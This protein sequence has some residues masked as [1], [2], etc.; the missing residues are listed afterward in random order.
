MPGKIVSTFDKVAADLSSLIEK[1][2]KIGQ[3]N[4]YKLQSD[5]NYYYKAI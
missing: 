3:R 4:F 5:K 1:D 2:K